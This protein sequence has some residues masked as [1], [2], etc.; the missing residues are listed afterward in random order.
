MEVISGFEDAW[1]FPQCF[2][3]IDGSHIPILSPHDGATDYYNRKDIIL[4][5][6]KLWLTTSIFS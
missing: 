4:L 3:A 1:G 2:G 6:C 5:Y